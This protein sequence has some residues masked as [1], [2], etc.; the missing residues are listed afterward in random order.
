MKLTLEE[1]LDK[2]SD[3][4]ILSQKE[5]VKYMA[6][7]FTYL[8]DKEEFSPA[9]VF[10][11]FKKANLKSPGNIHEEFQRLILNRKGKK[12]IF[13][14]IKK[15][16]YSFQRNSKKEISQEILGL[17]GKTKVSSDLRNLLPKVKEKESR[18]FLEEA[19]KCYEFSCS[20]ATVVMVWLLVIDTLY[21]HTI[22]K[23]LL[24]F[25]NALKKHGKYAKKVTI[26]TKDDFSDIKDYDF[27]EILKVGKIIDKNIKK[28][29]NNQ[30]D[31]RNLCAHPNSIIIRESK[32]I[33]FVEDLIENVIVRFQ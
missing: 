25:N 29:L 31:F 1:L 22:N 3:L 18:N 20:R 19:I 26:K 30:L 28:I 23:K 2:K 14:K 5:Q 21:E 17:P 12:A 15:N 16:T 6:F 27:I 11:L 24:I 10:E 32:V 9:K 7:F 33:A 4:D 8:N 13:L